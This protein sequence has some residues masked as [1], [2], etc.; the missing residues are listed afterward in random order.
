MT[1]FLLKQIIK[2]NSG[3][4]RPSAL[5]GLKLIIFFSSLRA[6]FWSKNKGGG[7]GEG[8]PGPSPG[9]ASD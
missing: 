2:T 3:G 5:G 4:S 9:S 7:G 8:G 6:S 1:G